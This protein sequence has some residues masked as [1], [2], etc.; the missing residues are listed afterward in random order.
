[1]RILFWIVIAPLAVLVTVF[2]VSNRG[3][4]T[5]DLWPLP[6]VIETPIFLLVL[7]C[8]LVGFL[9]GTFVAWLAGGK[10][11]RRARLKAAEAAASAR[12]A[13]RLKERIRQLEAPPPSAAL[14]LG[15]PR[16]A[17]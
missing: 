5:V 16:D 12:E 13:E 10:A 3:Q 15:S 17:A 7:L 2:A 6:F 9:I 8:G 4:V 14:Q 11:R 1:M